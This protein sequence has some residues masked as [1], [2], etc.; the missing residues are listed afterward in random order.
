MIVAL[1]CKVLVVASNLYSWAAFFPMGKGSERNT[2]LSD[3]KEHVSN[4]T[5]TSASVFHPSIK[6]AQP[7]L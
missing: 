6:T 7:I 4:H 1:S 3:N 5:L 2:A